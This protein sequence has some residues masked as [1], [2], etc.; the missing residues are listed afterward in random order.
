MKLSD[1]QYNAFVKEAEEFH[2]RVDAKL[3]QIVEDVDKREVVDFILDTYGY[4]DD[5]NERHSARIKLSVDY[6]IIIKK[7]Y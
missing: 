1:A 2:E 6:D 5:I 7:R 3:E 4:F